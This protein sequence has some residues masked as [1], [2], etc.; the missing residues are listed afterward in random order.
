[1]KGHRHGCHQLEEG[2]GPGLDTPVQYDTWMCRVTTW[3]RSDGKGSRGRPR[4]DTERGARGIPEVHHWAEKSSRQA[5]LKE[6]VEAFVQPGYK[7]A[8]AQ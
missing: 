1:M 6:H 8:A 4:L 3:K 7:Y 5:N 2:S